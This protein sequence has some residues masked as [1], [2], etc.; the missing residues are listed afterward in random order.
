MSARLTQVIPLFFV[1]LWSTGFINAKYALPYIEPFYFLT[2]RMVL[3]AMAFLLL[4]VVLK[5]KWPSLP[6]SLLQMVIGMLLHGVYLGGVFYAVHLGMP[7]GISSIFVGLHP[8]LTAFLGWVLLSQNLN[9]KQTFG[10]VFGFV[11]ISLVVFGSSN[12][13]GSALSILGVMACVLSLLGMSVSGIMQKIYAKKVP[14]LSGTFC[15]YIGATLV[16]LPMTYLLEDQTILPSIEFYA[17][18]IWSVL[19]LSVGAILL[20][21]Y[22]IREGEVAK[23]ASYFYLVPPVTVIQT[24]FLFGESLSVMAILGCVLAV[25]G[26]YLVA[27]TVK[28]PS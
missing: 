10:L 26:V 28:S 5:K 17:A 21:M 6:A 2:L 19:A 1:W 15:Q 16:L 22:M 13:D 11:G 4:I 12:I 24:W 7:A 8:A 27:K 25:M 18:L 23:V 3:A 9:L 20:L 14:L